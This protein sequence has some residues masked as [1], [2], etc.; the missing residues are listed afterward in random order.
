MSKGIQP[1]F[2]RAPTDNDKGGE[3]QSYL[4]KW[5]GAKLNNLTFI[6]ESC[7]VLNVSDNLVK[8]TIVYLGV[9]NGAE[10]NL[11]QSETCLF[12]VDL[13]YSIYGSGDVILECHVKPN[14]YLPPLP[15]VG[16]EFHLDKSMDHIQW[17]GRGPFECYPDRKA[18]AHVGVYEQ[19]VGSLHVPYIVPYECSGRADVRWVAFRNKEGHGIYASTY[20]GSPPMQMNASYYGT[21]ELERATHIEK[22][23][24]G[25]DI[26]VLFWPFISLKSFLHKYL[27]LKLHVWFLGG[28]VILGLWT[29]T[30]ISMIVFLRQTLNPR[31]SE[32]YVR[33]TKFVRCGF[34]VV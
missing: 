1:C 21:A 32:L 4:S 20:G 9:P 30:T 16:I 33:V 6:T 8:I 15:R 28:L 10:K 24:K 17:Y 12:K 11:S 19:D 29:I 31:T 3:A 25:D 27:V 23:V 18:A 26:E 34:V 7:T 2:W 5:K 22:L 13:V 14:S